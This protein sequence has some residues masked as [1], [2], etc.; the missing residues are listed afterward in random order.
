METKANVG[1]AYTLFLQKFLASCIII[2]VKKKYQA[3]TGR[4]CAWETVS[5]RKI[6]GR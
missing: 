3:T 2:S 1:W 5:Q 6:K 4:Y